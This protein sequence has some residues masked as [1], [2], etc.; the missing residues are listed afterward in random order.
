M[1]NIYWFMLAILSLP[2]VA[3]VLVFWQVKA[4]LKESVKKSSA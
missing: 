2:L 3:A 1:S 4:W